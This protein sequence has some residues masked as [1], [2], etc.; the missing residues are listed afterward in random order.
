MAL[1]RTGDNGC[2]TRSLRTLLD[3]AVASLSEAGVPDPQV[4]A[5]LL[6]GHVTRLSRG[7]VHAAIAMDRALSD[8]ELAALASVVA[9]RASREPLQHITGRAPF[10]SLDL[11]VGPGVFVPRPET[12]LL[13]GL[14]IDE[15]QSSA[16]VAP[17]AVDFGT[18]SGAIA[19]SLA[20][21][22]P[23]ARVF[24]VEVSPEAH[25]WARRNIDESGAD[26]TLILG[27]LALPIAELDSLEG[28]VSVV[29][30]NPP[31]VPTDAVPRDP[32]VR[33]FDPALALY[34]GEDGLELVRALSKR[35]RRLLHP[36]GLFV[37]EHGELQGG[38]IRD[39][40]AGD[41]WRAPE[42]HRD[43]LGRDRMTLARR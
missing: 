41:G 37:V 24:A 10:R 34:G 29:V 25:A 39:L 40:L 3:D 21:E 36:G 22:V 23:H 13:A 35:A 31:Y 17:I 27:D 8:A 32:E 11:A 30:S 5:E 33:N 12:E 16:S 9:R 19:L 7:G 1:P 28:T 43:L 38:E 6:L 2:V 18:G 20:M 14:A 26:L 42:T 4:D 15:L